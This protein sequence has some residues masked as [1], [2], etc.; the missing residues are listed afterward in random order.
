MVLSFWRGGGGI[1]VAFCFRER[2]R[3]DRDGS[4]RFS[5]DVDRRGRL[6]R[7]RWGTVRKV[8]ELSV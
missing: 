4:C 6:T 5:L 3:F 2:R 1:V 8:I 7:E